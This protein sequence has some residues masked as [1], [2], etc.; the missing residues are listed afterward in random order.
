MVTQCLSINSNKLYSK[1]NSQKHQ[2][3]SYEVEQKWALFKEYKQF[4]ET[5]IQLM[6]KLSDK[7]S[8]KPD[9]LF[10]AMHILDQL[11]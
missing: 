8:F 2:A 6:C 4:R 10:L 11:I 7:Y 3:E 5:S 1:Q 9:T